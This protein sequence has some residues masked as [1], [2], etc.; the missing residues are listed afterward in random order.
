MNIYKATVTVAHGTG[1]YKH[2][3]HHYWCGTGTAMCRSPKQ[4]VRLARRQADQACGE[5][6]AW[7]LVWLDVVIERK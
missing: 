5:G 7:M 1:G 2:D 3:P 4:A 6:A